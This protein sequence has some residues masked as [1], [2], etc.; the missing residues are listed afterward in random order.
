MTGRWV[1]VS[2]PPRRVIVWG[3]GD[4]LRVDAPILRSLG[5]VIE[6]LIDDTPGLKSPIEGIPLFAGERG[7]DQY[8]SK[9]TSPSEVGFV[10][11][12]GNPFGDV[13]VRLHELMKGK[14]LKPVSLADETARIC[15][16]AAYGEGLH[17]MP[18]AVVHSDA[19]LGRQ[20]LINTRAL[21]EHDCVLE[22]GVEIGPGAV[23]CGRVTVG[24]Y[25]WVAANA[26]VRPR[27]RIGSNSIIG[28][29]A[30]VVSDVPD[31]VVVVGVPARAVKNNPQR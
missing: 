27:V 26:T 22:D 29:G 19:R 5:C 12:I 7:L 31:N 9:T 8:L 14:D 18:F 30:V 4:Q 16:T 25:S 23:L 11:A 28:A 24:R 20:C 2:G 21:V 15:V 3:A 10:V 1:T 13:R 6:A 17:A